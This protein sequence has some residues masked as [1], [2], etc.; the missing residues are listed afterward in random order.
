MAMSAA[1]STVL[2]V[3]RAQSFA[4]WWTMPWRRVGLA[5]ILALSAA[6]E[7]IGLTDEGY[8]NSYYAAGVK[9][10]LTSWHNFFFVSY[11]AGG[12]VSLDKPPL[13]L[14]I[15]AASAKVFGFSS[16]SL[17]APE[18]LAGVLAVALLYRLVARPF[19]PAAGLLAALMLALTPISMVI[20]RNNTID[21]LLILALLLAA[22]ALSAAATR[23]SLRL[24]LLAAVLVGLG[25]NIKMLQAY[26]VVPA[27]GAVYLLGAP[28]R[29]RA[30]LAHLLLSALTLLAVSFA[31][32][33][34]VDLTPA[35][36]RPF[37]S[38]SGT[39]SML[40][41]VFGYNGLGR[42]TQALFPN[43]HYLHI[44]GISIDLTIVPAF[45]PNIGDPGWFRLFT[46]AVGGQASWLL[47][48]ALVGL[49]A[50]IVT[51]RP[52]LPLDDRG[53]ALVLWGGW[54]L[55]AGI[56]FSTAR[57]YHLYYLVMLAPAIAALAGIGCVV[58]WQAYIAPSGGRLRHAISWLLP[59]TLAGTAFVELHLLDGYPNGSVWPELVAVG[60]SALAIGVLGARLLHLELMVAPG[61][62]LRVGARLAAG[63]TLASIAALL[64]APAA[65][66]MLAIG[67]G[68]GGAWLPQA[69]PASS[70]FGGGFGGGRGGGGFGQRGGFQFNGGSAS[71]GGSGQNPAGGQ[72]S[73]A[74]APGSGSTGFG[75][76]NG[77]TGQ[78]P[79]TGQQSNAA[80]PG[81]G[82]PGFGSGQGS[83]SGQ[84]FGSGTTS[85]TGAGP[86]A[87]GFGQGG[88]GFSFGGRGGGG[89][90][91]AMTYAGNQIPTLN[92]GL[93]RYLEKNQGSARYL[94]AT[95]TSSYASLFILQ[96]NQPAMALGGY[97]G[98]DRVL[99]PTSLAKLVADGA[100]RFFYLQASGGTFQAQGGFSAARPAGRTPP[101]RRAICRM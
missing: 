97:Q 72:Q 81:S 25:F 24:L 3:P 20:N 78:V 14:W 11:D 17:L 5:L 23:G 73:G 92:A 18:A 79:A 39:N 60:G 9:S 100:V 31:W 4:M 82:S 96:T 76:R 93:L 75:G 15:Q 27:F 68:Q 90:G 88:A 62:T 22:W 58:M 45:A 10:M 44:L 53:Q 57:F 55:M 37:I 99:T 63:I 91:G 67:D 6:V 64:V 54:L 13:G 94:V 2:P 84:G 66:G 95:A 71:A 36:Q 47:L 87:Q 41:L 7:F 46:P 101:R 21:S 1:D 26:L 51:L 12:F 52:R 43:V 80:A 19:G 59:A 77:G 42:L 32:V 28:I 70:G 86:S 69:G 98:W 65:W 38:D 30:R 29:L 89:G 33:L 56:F 16:L 35:S 50:A 34:A 74:T 61:T 40:S 83:T 48:P 49:V 8:A 85:S